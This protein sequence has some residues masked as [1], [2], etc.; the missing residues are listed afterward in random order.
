MLFV[1]FLYSVWLVQCCSMQCHCYCRQ[2]F[3]VTSVCVGGMSDGVVE[4]L[5]E[6]EPAN[7]V[8]DKLQ[9]SL[10]Q[11]LT[12]EKR[13]ELAEVLQRVDK[14]ILRPMLV[15]VATATTHVSMWIVNT[16]TLIY[17]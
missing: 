9:M 12:N 17:N 14:V 10:A 6:W 8:M 16:F 3:T 2:V 1:I 5:P 13:E 7:M 15:V 4:R 11:R